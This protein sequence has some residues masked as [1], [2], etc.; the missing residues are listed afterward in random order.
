M[1]NKVFFFPFFLFE[2]LKNLPG[3]DNEVVATPVTSSDLDDG[4]GRGGG[5]YETAKTN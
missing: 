4:N 5:L 2:D 3:I 1:N